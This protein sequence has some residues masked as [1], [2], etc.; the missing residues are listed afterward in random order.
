MKIM[1]KIIIIS[2]IVIIFLSVSIPLGYSFI[3]PVEAITIYCNV[4]ANMDAQSC[5]SEMWVNTWMQQHC[6]N[7]INYTIPENPQPVN[8]DCISKIQSNMILEEE[9][10]QTKLLEK[11]LEELQTKRTIIVGPPN[12]PKL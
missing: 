4:L 5:A 6:Y 7:L 1:N 9:N 3:L 11:I 2:G 10:K 8:S 12:N